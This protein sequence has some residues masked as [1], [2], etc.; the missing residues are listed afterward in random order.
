MISRASIVRFVFAIIRVIPLSLLV[1]AVA[2]I[3]SDFAHAIDGNYT[4]PY[5]SQ[6]DSRSAA[7]TIPNTTL[8]GMLLLIVNAL[9]GAFYAIRHRLGRR[10][11]A[12]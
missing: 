8:L 9:A 7:A 12:A 3:G 2:I 6:Y 11:Q 4:S 10:R 1:A 5:A